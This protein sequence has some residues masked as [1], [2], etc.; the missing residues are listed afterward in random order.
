MK[1]PEGTLTLQQACDVLQMSRQAFYQAGLK[2]ILSPWQIAAAKPMLFSAR[3]VY[4][5]AVWRALRP[6]MIADGMLP[7]RTPLARKD[8]KELV[9]RYRKMKK[10]TQQKEETSS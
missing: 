3:Q 2:E 7:Y 9:A 1:Q 10:A 5:F 4:E 8:H 6:Q